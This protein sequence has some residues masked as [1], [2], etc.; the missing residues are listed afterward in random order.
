MEYYSLINKILVV[1]VNIFS[2]WL[3]LWV[4]FADRRNKLN[5]IFLLWVISTSLW[6]TMY[7]LVISSKQPEMAIFF[8]KM[9]HGAV[10]LFYI[11]FYLFFIYFLNLERRL[12]NIIT[13]IYILGLVLFIFSTSTN[14]IVK[15]IEFRDTGTDIILASGAIIFYLLAGFSAIF[16]IT[17]LIRK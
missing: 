9:G 7:Y 6:I 3:G 1:S 2:L 5:R 16:V 11:P 8:A 14:L 10:S 15:G 13:T 12:K 17:L 4:Y